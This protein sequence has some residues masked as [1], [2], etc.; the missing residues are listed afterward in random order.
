[1]GLRNV[2]RRVQHTGGGSYVVTLPKQ[3]VLR[4]GVDKSGEVVV[5]VEPDGSLR[6]RPVGGAARERKS[7]RLVFEEPGVE[8]LLREVVSYYIAGADVIEVV[9]RGQVQ[10]GLARRVR[11][12]V[13]ARLMGVEVVEESSDSLVFQVV[14]DPTSME[15]EKS[16][17]RLARTVGHMLEDLVRGIEGDL[18]LLEEIP[19]RDDI[20]DK[21]FMFIWRQVFLLLSGWV[22]AR[23]LGVRSL[24]DAVIVMTAAK[25]LERIGDH[26]SA[27]ALAAA[28]LLRG[29]PKCLEGFRSHVADIAS[30]YSEAIL[31]L[32]SPERTK[33]EELL[34]RCRVLRA[35]NDELTGGH[36]C[37]GLEV[38]RLLHGARRL[39][40]YTV[41]VLELALNRLALR[42]LEG[43]TG[44]GGQG[45]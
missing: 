43:E 25:H 31:L 16:L 22:T 7:V 44:R 17:A 1:L 34:R 35:R 28:R 10:P 23:Q 21:L 30:L 39:I 32:G 12:V 2:V 5:S 29:E 33:I 18:E 4:Y 9:L 40:D 45:G 13:S 6:L 37:T 3:W 41:D 20:V 15:L 24:G 27:M 19:S 14:L 8:E 36:G 42:R 26:A 38:Y 11:S